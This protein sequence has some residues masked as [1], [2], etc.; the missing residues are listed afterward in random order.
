MTTTEEGLTDEQKSI[1]LTYLQS[2]RLLMAHVSHALDT[3]GDD[4]VGY[5]FETDEGDPDIGFYSRQDFLQSTS[6]LTKLK[7]MAEVLGRIEANR[8]IDTIKTAT[9][10][11]QFGFW[12]VFFFKGCDTPFCGAFSVQRMNARGGSA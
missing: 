6:G 11:N 9:S 10:D 3:I 5:M 4:I 7:G 1:I 2:N 8:A 12:L